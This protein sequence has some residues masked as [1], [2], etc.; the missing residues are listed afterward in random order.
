MSEYKS[1]GWSLASPDGGVRKY[2][3]KAGPAKIYKTK[4]V[5]ERNG[6]PVE[7]FVK[8]EEKA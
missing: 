3:P 8:E 6:N 2:G 4:E 1:V 7:V 5:A